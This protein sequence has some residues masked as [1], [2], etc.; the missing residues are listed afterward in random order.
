M[1]ANLLVLFVSDHIDRTRR[2]QAKDDGE[3]V[4]RAVHDEPGAFDALV[5]RYQRRATGLAYGLLN[6]R[7]DAMEVVQEAFLNAFD[8]LKTLSKPE[9]FGAWFLRIVGNL[10]LNRRRAR[11]L[12]K[13]VPL[14]PAGDDDC[15]RGGMQIPD[16]HAATPDE[17]ASAKELRGLIIEGIEELPPMQRQ[18]LILF[19]VAKMPQQQIAE[20]LGCTVA[21][22][23]WNV[24]AARK[25]L[26]ETLKDYL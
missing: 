2:R 10:S 23:K 5:A 14:D 25:K 7:D 3:L 8:K 17:S 18:A 4:R 15:S 6:N 9:R 12:R 11:A 24:F 22:V 21:A 16:T 20:E 13:F 19:A 26:K 1:R